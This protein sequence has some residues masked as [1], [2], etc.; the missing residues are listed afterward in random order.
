MPD[1]AAKEDAMKEK[2]GASSSRNADS[3]LQ[4]SNNHEQEVRFA[5]EER[6]ALHVERPTRPTPP[7]RPLPVITVSQL[8]SLNFNTIIYLI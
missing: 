3:Y 2:M 8:Q 6:Q 1:V 5:A 4:N 7:N